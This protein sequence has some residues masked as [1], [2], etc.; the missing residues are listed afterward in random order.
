MPA[1]RESTPFGRVIELLRD[2]DG[3][4]PT[5]YKWGN[6]KR[7]PG[8]EFLADMIMTHPDANVGNLTGP[9]SETTVVDVDDPDL[10]GTAIERF[11]NTPVISRTPSGGVHL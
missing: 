9:M 11:G 5:A 3:K 4:Q 8:S 2:P 6:W 10:V 7:R 1:S